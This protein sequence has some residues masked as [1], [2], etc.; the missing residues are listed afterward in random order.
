MSMCMSVYT[1][2]F[3]CIYT[4]WKLLKVPIF[5]ISIWSTL[6]IG[7]QRSLCY[8]L[9]DKLHIINTRKLRKEVN[10]VGKFFIIFYF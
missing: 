8:I 9:A 2:V 6:R 7:W 10:W 1:Y 5:Q 4:L 3:R